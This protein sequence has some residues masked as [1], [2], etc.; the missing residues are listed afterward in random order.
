MSTFILIQSRKIPGR[1]RCR[2]P[3][4]E[5]V[6]LCNILCKESGNAELRCISTY[7]R[8]ITCGNFNILRKFFKVLFYLVSYSSFL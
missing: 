3:A 1:A 4:G 5:N 2:E 7:L 8:K 6:R